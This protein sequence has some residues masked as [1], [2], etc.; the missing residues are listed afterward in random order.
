LKVTSEANY[1]TWL[2]SCQGAEESAHWQTQAPLIRQD[3]IRN[4]VYA[5]TKA[6]HREVQDREHS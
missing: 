1:A 6:T 5:A 3:I 4:C 2:E